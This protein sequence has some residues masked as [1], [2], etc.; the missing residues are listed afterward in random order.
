MLRVSLGVLGALALVAGCFETATLIPDPVGGAGGSGASTGGGGQAG[1][2]PGG[3]GGNPSTGGSSAGG[4]GG[5]GGAPCVPEDCA[6]VD[7]DCRVRACDPGCTFEMLAEGTS[8]DDDGG[9]ACDGNGQ[10]VECTLP[11]H[12]TGTDEVCVNNT[13]VP[14]ALANG[15]AC[16]GD[17]QCVSGA[18]AVDDGVCCDTACTGTCESCIGS[19]T[20]NAS[21]GT[22]APIVA[23]TDPDAECG[24]NT[25]FAGQCLSGTIVFASSSLQNGAMG[26]LTGAD[27]ICNDLATTACLPGTY[28]AWLSDDTDSPTTRFNTAQNIPYRLVDG[29]SISLNW[30]GLIDNFIDAPINLDETGQPAPVSSEVCTGNTNMVYT[31]TNQNGTVETDKHCNN[32]TSTTADGVWGDHTE[33]SN[34]WSAACTGA[35]GTCDRNAPIYCFQQ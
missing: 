8:C 24:A 5:S 15:D 25:C 34:L 30:A 7:T 1:G 13:C 14:G 19:K 28:L 6:G 33:A 26:G 17:A 21:D 20:C 31:G 22:C 27:T 3:T 9:I 32:W 35:G 18:C 16:V 2:N 10:C 11:A 12:C 4:T 23:G 29:T